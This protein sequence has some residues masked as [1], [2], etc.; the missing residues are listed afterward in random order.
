MIIFE[1]LDYLQKKAIFYLKKA[2]EELPPNKHREMVKNALENI[3]KAINMDEK[4]SLN[5]AIKT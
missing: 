2:N 5:Y 3:N 4:N 1:R